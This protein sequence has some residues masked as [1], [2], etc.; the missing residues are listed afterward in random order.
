LIRTQVLRPEAIEIV[1]RLDV[2][3]GRLK[4][5]PALSPD[6]VMPLRGALPSFDLGNI[7]AYVGH[8]MDGLTSRAAQVG[9]P[10]PA[11]LC[12]SPRHSL[13]S[14]EFYELQRQ[15]ASLIQG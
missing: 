9:N 11:G 3:S 1:L 13:A 2:L 5:A 4:S 15:R 6:V 12:F 10:R 14:D 7:E 8:V